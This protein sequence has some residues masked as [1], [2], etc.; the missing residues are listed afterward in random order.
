MRVVLVVGLGA[1]P[2]EEG[3][4]ECGGVEEAVDVTAEDAGIRRDCAVGGAVVEANVRIRSS[5]P[6]GN[7]KVHFVTAH[8]GAGDEVRAGDGAQLFV[9]C[10]GRGD[11]EQ[12]EAAGG[13][14]VA[15]DALRVEYAGAEHLIAGTN[16]EDA[17]ASAHVCKQVDV[18]AL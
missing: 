12:A 5:W 6:A 13:I 3:R 2:G 18:P 8:S 16:A 17:A 1:E 11:V 14:L 15:F 7:S 4:A 10:H 9:A